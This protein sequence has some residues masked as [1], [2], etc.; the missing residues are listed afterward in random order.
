MSDKLTKQFFLFLFS[1]KR[2][3]ENPE[4]INDIFDCEII[5]I[6]KRPPAGR[7]EV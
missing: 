6:I 7:V 1:F 2:K 3:K 5:N 4:K